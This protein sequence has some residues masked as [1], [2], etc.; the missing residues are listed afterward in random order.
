MKQPKTVGTLDD[1]GRT[2]LSQH[3]YMRDFLVSDIAAIHSLNNVPDDPD[4]PIEAGTQLCQELLEP[5][6]QVFGRIAIRS[7]YRSCEVN[8]FG[9]TNG[10][11]CA[12]N[13]RNYAA[14]IW[15]RRDAQG[16]MGAT[17]CIVIPEF[18]DA[19]P[20]PGEWTKLAWW[21]HDHLPYSNL[22]FFQ[23][24]WAVNVTWHEQ[25]IRRIDSWAGH[26]SLDGWTTKRLSTKP[27]MPN[28]DVGHEADWQTLGNHFDLSR[29]TAPQPQMGP[30]F[31][32]ISAS[33]REG[34]LG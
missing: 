32:K 1:F 34:T 11:N 25:P 18:V 22:C 20:K 31:S 21:I 28:H 27:G 2:R 9:N 10:Y 26:H 14:H 23:S 3:F 5:I 7:A 6:Q 33:D 4:L 15:D 19:L 29:V 17:A 30:K 8:A 16:C 24:N 12:S 13:E